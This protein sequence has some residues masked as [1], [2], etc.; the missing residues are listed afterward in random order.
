MRIHSGW[1]A[2]VFV[3]AAAQGGEVG[4]EETFAL[5]QDRGKTLE[6][7]SRSLTKKRFSLFSSSLPSAVNAVG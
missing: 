6:Q 2:L 7:L 3:C 5:S 1:F 4:F